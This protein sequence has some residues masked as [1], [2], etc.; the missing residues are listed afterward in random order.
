VKL[1]NIDWNLLL[2]IRNDTFNTLHV[3]IF[4]FGNDIGI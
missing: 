3:L 1:K 4:E 2:F